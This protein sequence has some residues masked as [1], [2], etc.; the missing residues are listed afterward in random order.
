MYPS[1][2]NLKNSEIEKREKAAFKKM[3]SCHVCPRHCKVNR[4]KNEKGFCNLGI[5]PTISSF[6]A[7]FGEEECLV[8]THGSGTIFFTWCNLR[9]VYCQNYEIS[10]LGIGNE[11]E[12]DKLAEI[13][14]RLQS[15]GCHNI[16]LVTPTPQVPQILTGLKI[17]IKKGLKMLPIVY[18]SSGYDSVETLK[19]LDGIVDI[20]MPDFKYSDERTAQKYSFAPRYPEVA[21]KAIK[22]MHRQVGDLTI[23]KSGIAKRGLLIRHLVLPRDIAGTKKIMNFLSKEISR[24][25]FVNIMDQYRPVFKASRFP[26]LNR[27]ATSQE[28]LRARESA[29]EADLKRIY[30][31]R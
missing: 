14:V 21:K 31:L 8:G 1:Y 7:H 2:L 17:A 4:L 5:K 18:N 11:I 30:P 12:N 24:N 22:E 27:R 28:Y 29:E 10:H 19:L 25:T 6:H 26:S 15:Y 9:C 13:M 20:Y 23:D 16:N 3:I